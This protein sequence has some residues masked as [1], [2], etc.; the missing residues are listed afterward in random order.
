MFETQTTSDVL[1]VLYISVISQY[2]KTQWVVL[3]E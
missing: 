2:G 1:S 3:N